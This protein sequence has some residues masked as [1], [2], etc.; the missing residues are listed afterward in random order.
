MASPFVYALGLVAGVSLIYELGDRAFERR[1]ARAERRTTPSWDR[2]NVS[3]R[4]HLAA[5]SNDRPKTGRNTSSNDD[6]YDAMALYLGERFM[7][8]GIENEEAQMFAAAL[9]SVSE[10]TA[11]S[12]GFDAVG[13]EITVKLK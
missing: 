8:R 10:A 13:V 11:I 12:D 1:I 4:E 2:S 3:Y 6:T 7:Q 5:V 9:M